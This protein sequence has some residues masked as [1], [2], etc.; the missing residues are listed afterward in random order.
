M[1]STIAKLFGKSPFF[2]LQNHMEKV[3]LCLS[4]LKKLFDSIE[5]IKDEKKQKLI[6]KVSLFE[7]E[8]DIVKN[9]IR[10]HLPRSIVLPIDRTRFLEILALQDSVA[11]MAEE[12]ALYLR[13][14]E[15]KDIHIFADT[16]KAYVASSLRTFDCATAIIK[17]FD[18]LIESMFGGKEAQRVK[19]LVMTTAA[20]D[21]ETKKL[22]QEMLDLLY[23]HGETFSPPA[24][25][26]WSEVI[27]S[28]A[29]IAKLSERL[30]NRVRMTLDTK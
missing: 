11:D 20:C 16:L 28:I 1:R 4:K 25:H 6:E 24:F 29:L 22:K 23:L 26:Q 18:H 9:D 30:A 13:Q 15:L 10:N 5:S 2:L 17:D 8:A 14:R 27:D 21:N 19:E 3:Q 12:T 7:H